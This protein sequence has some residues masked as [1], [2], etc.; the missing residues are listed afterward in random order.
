M[1]VVSDSIPENNY[2]IWHKSNESPIKGKLFL[3]E[4]NQNIVDLIRSNGKDMPDWCNRWA[5]LDDLLKI[6]SLPCEPSSE[7]LEE[8]IDRFEDWLNNFNQ[9]DYPTSLTVRD[10]A[11]HFAEWQ[12]RKDVEEMM[13]T[14]VGGE[15]VKDIHNQLSVKSEPLNDAFGKFGD[16]VKIIVVKDNKQ[17]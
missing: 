10:I 2:S 11:R 6:A 1:G 7:D 5:Y 14:L 9:S 17:K 4:T 15:I 3:Y 16:K 13:K 12:K 8:E